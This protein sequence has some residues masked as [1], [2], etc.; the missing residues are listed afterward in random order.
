MLPEKS[1]QVRF[2]LSELPNVGRLLNAPEDTPTQPGVPDQEVNSI[3]QWQPIHF[4]NLGSN[5]V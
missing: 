5:T 3:T 4:I 2:V 1:V